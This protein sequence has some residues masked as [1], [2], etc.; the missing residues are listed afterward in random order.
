[1]AISTLIILPR[2]NRELKETHQNSEED[3]YTFLFLT[4]HC[5]PNALNM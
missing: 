5:D 2:V 1:M 3:D 4:W